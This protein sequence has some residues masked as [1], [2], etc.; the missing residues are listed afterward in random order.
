MYNSVKHSIGDSLVTDGIIPVFH[1]ELRGH[2]DGFP[3][4]A[5]FDDFQQDG[6]LLGIQRYKEGIIEDEQLT[7]LYLLQLRLYGVL[8]FC[9]LQG[10]EQL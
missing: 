7:P 5:V 2:D 10:A 4:M 3:V 1:G 8:G 9:H 6:S